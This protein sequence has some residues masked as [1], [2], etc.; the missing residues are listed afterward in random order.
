MTSVL[1]VDDVR[2]D[3]IITD[4]IRAGAKAV[5]TC[6]RHDRWT[7]LKCAFVPH[8]TLGH[9]IVVTHPLQEPPDQGQGLEVGQRVGVAFRRGHRKYLLST[10]VETPD[11]GTSPPTGTV[12]LRWPNSIHQIQRRVCHRATPPPGR[13]IHVQVRSG[14]IDN[15]NTPTPPGA[16]ILDGRVEDLSVGGI[17]VLSPHDPSLPAD[18]PVICSFCIDPDTQPTTLNAVFRH[19]ETRHDRFSLG[20]QFVGLEARRDGPELLARLAAIVT[21]FQRAAVRQRSRARRLRH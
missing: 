16:P 8:E 21:R 2:L 7:T 9:R 15:D 20:F 3:Q 5:L 17:R 13:T 1:S 19:R 14:H 18:A 11:P 12:V 10:V 6:R 4:A